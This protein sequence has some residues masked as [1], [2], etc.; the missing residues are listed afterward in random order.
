MDVH[1]LY[2]WVNYQVFARELDE[3]QS[4]MQAS[5]GTHEHLILVSRCIWAVFK[6]NKIMKTF[7]LQ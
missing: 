6:T 4:L 2:Q 7:Q 3:V 1:P 5:H